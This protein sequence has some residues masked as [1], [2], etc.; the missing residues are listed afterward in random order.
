MDKMGYNLSFTLKTR[1]SQRC[2]PRNVGTDQ[3][4]LARGR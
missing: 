1:R 4:Q 2:Q 3:A